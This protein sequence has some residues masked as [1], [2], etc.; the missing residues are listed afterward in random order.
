MVTLLTMDL[1]KI[2]IIEKKERCLVTVDID[3]DTSF[4]QEV[5]MIRRAM[6][7]AAGKWC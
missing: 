5:E 2:D 1:S 6:I 7:T 3:K 4:E